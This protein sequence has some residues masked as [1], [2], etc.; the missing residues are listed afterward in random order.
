MAT[1]FKLYAD[2]MGATDPTAYIGRDG[3]IFYNPDTGSLRRSD[4][5]TPGGVAI[6][7]GGGGGDL[8][9]DLTPQLGGT[10]D[11]NGQEITGGLIPSADVTYDLGSNTNRWKDLYL[12]G[13]SIDLGGVTISSS[14]GKIDL[15]AGEY[16]RWVCCRSYCSWSSQPQLLKMVSYR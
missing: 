1:T 11:I 15:P 2:K 14:D 8:V 4:G 5:T 10:L 12:S 7:T 6:A 3:D 16:N 13:S 9:D